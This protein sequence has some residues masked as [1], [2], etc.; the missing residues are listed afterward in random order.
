MRDSNIAK[1]SPSIVTAVS[2]AMAPIDLN[3]TLLIFADG[4]CS[5]NPGPGGWGSI[6]CTPR[7]EVLELGGPAKQTTNN[8][9]ELQAVIQALAEVRSFDGPVAVLTDSVYVIRGI[10]QWIWGWRK[11]EWKTAQGDPVSNKEY[12]SELSRLVAQRGKS[13]T[14]HYVRG[15]SGIPGNERTDK[16]ATTFAKGGRPQLYRGGLL[17]YPV[18]LHDLPENTDL[19][20]PKPLENQRPAKAAAYSYLSLVGNTAKRHSTWAECESRVKGVS[21]AKFKKTA[22]AEDEEEILA[23]WGAEI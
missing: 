4:A 1:E 3:Q 20:P 19:P 8:Q 14:W 5:G 6:I 15:H 7:G 12:W 21:G 13:M 22:S 9:M 10:T 2:S 23:A 18:P 16:I 11:R 17:D